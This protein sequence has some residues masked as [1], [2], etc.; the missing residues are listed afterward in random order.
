MSRS[1]SSALSGRNR[2]EL[3]GQHGSKQERIRHSLRAKRHWR[4]VLAADGPPARRSRVDLAVVRLPKRSEQDGEM[5]FVMLDAHGRVAF[6]KNVRRKFAWKL[7]L[8]RRG[9][10]VEIRNHR[11]EG[12]FVVQ[13]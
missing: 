7:H 5:P 8:K 11:F 4:E 2:R 3:P 10:L 6:H 1:M 9:K 13:C 12:F